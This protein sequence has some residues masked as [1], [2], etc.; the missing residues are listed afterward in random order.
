[1]FQKPVTLLHVASPFACWLL[2][3]PLSLATLVALAGPTLPRP[4]TWGNRPAAY[5]PADTAF[6][7][8]IRGQIL[9]QQ[10]QPLEFTTVLL[11][12]V[13][14]STLVSSLLSDE[15]GRYVFA[16][17]AAGR[18]YVQAKQLGYRDGRSAVVQVVAGEP[19][20]RLP[21]LVLVAAPRSWLK[22]R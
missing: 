8:G 10:R 21:P 16:D 5:P 18:Y 13:S 3:A 6:R 17:V 1:M 22:C 12:R 20:L 14:D 9:G 2:A 19:G 15:Q 11:R 4:I 7:A